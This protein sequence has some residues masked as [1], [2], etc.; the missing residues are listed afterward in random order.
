MIGID[1]TVKIF[2]PTAQIGSVSEPMENMDSI[3]HANTGPH[4]RQLTHIRF[5]HRML[6]TLMSRMANGRD[7]DDEENFAPTCE[8]Q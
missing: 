6:A 1:S 8:V 7:P 4:Q 5:T 2:R 3:I